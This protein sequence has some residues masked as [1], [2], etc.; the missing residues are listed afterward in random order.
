MLRPAQRRFFNDICGDLA[1]QLLWHGGIHLTKDDYRHM[2][3]GTVM[4]WRTMPGISRDGE[5]RGWIMLGGSSLDLT[6]DQCADAIT[7]ALHIGDHP[8]DQGLPQRKVQWGYSVLRGLG[9]SDADIREL[10]A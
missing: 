1:D 10:A 6:K 7:L 2:L 4:G 3:A 5:P 8:E 9:Y